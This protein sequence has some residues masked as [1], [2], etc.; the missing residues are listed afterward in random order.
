MKKMD[1]K[2][3]TP[4]SL[5]FTLVYLTFPNLWKDSKFPGQSNSKKVYNF[6]HLVKCRAV[7]KRPNS[8][9]EFVYSPLLSKEHLPDKVHRLK[10][11]TSPYGKRKKKIITV[12]GSKHGDYA[13]NRMVWCM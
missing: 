7:N 9:G 12:Y 8:Q 13:Q 6:N 4:Q 11:I 3:N 2:T 10:L 1:R 5:P